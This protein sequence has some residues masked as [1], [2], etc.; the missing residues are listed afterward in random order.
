MA[1][2]QRNVLQGDVQHDRRMIITIA[3]DKNTN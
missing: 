3:L 1:M 2:P